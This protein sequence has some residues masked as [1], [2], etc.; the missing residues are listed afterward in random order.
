MSLV[1]VLIDNC[2]LFHRT[3]E[4][5]LQ[6]D[7]VLWVS[8]ARQLKNRSLRFLY[9]FRST[10]IVLILL[11]TGSRTCGY[12]ELRCD[13]GQCLDVRSFCMG[14]TFCRDGSRSEDEP[15]CGGFLV[16]KNSEAITPNMNWDY[17][18][19]MV[20]A[21]NHIFNTNQTYYVGYQLWR[22]WLSYRR[23]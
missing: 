19:N 13:N 8:T 14:E 7:S 2:W 15:I 20:S 23:N 3:R 4:I 22:W 9:Y 11:L 17:S 1:C 6:Q 12:N 18:S 5:S 16:L 10:E 21:A